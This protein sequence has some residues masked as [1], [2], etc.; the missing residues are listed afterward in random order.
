MKNGA[1]RPP[2]VALRHGLTGHTIL[3]PAEDQAAYDC[4]VQAFFDEYQPRT[5]TELQLTQELADTAWRLNRVAALENNL[6]TIGLS[7]TAIRTEHPQAQDA[8]GAAVAFRDNA[9]A[10]AALSMHGQRL[11]RQFERVLHTLRKLQDE[12][13]HDEIMR[14]HKAAALPKP[15]KIRTLTAPAPADGFALSDTVPAAIQPAG[16]PSPP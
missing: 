15:P 9:R 2:A 5:A 13:R 4:H 8:V 10:F 6:L 11:S 12:R 7:Q 16:T 1:S 3:L 14:P